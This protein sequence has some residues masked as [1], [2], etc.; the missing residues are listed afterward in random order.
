[1]PSTSSTPPSLQENQPFLTIEHIIKTYRKPN[2]ELFAVLNGI[3]MTLEKEEYVSVIG[4]SGCGKST[5]LRIVAGL[6]KATS[7]L[8]TMEGEIIRKPGVERMM[9]FQGYALLPWLT[10]RENIKM[11]EDV[12]KVIVFKYNGQIHIYKCEEDLEEGTTVNMQNNPPSDNTV[13][14]EQ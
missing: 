6:E 2:G 4:H 12:K 7:G 9:V 8:V 5:L 3:D 11:A 13:E 1:M 10:V 14:N